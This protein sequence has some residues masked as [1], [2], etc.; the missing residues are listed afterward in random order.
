MPDTLK[1]SLQSLS[2]FRP[3]SFLLCDH[4]LPSLFFPFCPRNKSPGKGKY[5]FQLLSPLQSL[6]AGEA[7]TAILHYISLIKL[8]KQNSPDRVA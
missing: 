1:T 4:F 6:S 5:L 8:P 7:L 2:P 3:I